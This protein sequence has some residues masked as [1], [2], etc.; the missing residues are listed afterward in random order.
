METGTHGLAPTRVSWAESPTS[1]SLLLWAEV[2]QSKAEELQDGNLSPCPTRP[3]Q[4][5]VT[6]Q[7]TQEAGTLSAVLNSNWSCKRWAPRLQKVKG[8]KLWRSSVTVK[9]LQ[10]LNGLEAQL[11]KVVTT[12]QGADR[13]RITEWSG[14][15]GTSVGHPVQPPC[16][17][18]VSYSRLHR[19]LCVLCPQPSSARGQ[20]GKPGTAPKGPSPRGEDAQFWPQPSSY[21]NR[22][23]TCREPT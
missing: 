1:G 14:L 11:R 10:P 19:T 6:A 8:S 7:Q 12:R 18:R 13:H 16:R 17:S 3:L 21:P 22:S 23:R 9:A 2:F 5:S 4:P 15:E 20:P